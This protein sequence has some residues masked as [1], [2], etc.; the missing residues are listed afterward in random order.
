MKKQRFTEEQIIAVLKEQEA[1]AKAAD[2]CRKHGISGA[3]FYN[4]K[5]KYGGI[6]IGTGRRSK[7][8]RC[9]TAVIVVSIGWVCWVRHVP[10]YRSS[11]NA[12]TTRWGISFALLSATGLPPSIGDRIY[13]ISSEPLIDLRRW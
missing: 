8:M 2:L 1:G 13:S 10:V 6:A 11:E 5:A 4:R 12:G 9:A 7:R 3:T